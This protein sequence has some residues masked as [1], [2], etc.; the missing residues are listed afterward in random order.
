MVTNM[1]RKV[2]A[3]TVRHRRAAL[4]LGVVVAGGN[5]AAVGFAPSLGQRL[6]FPLFTVVLALLVLGVVSWRI[7]PACFVVQ[8][9]IPAFAAP[10]PAWRVYLALGVL[11]PFSAQVG[12][13][14]RSSSQGNLWLPEPFLDV[15]WFLLAVLLFSDAWRGHGVQL[16]PHGIRQGYTLGS[17]TVP[18][19]ALPVGHP[20]TPTK[21]PSTLRLAYAEPHLVRRRG[22]PLNRNA[23]RTDDIDARFLAAAIRHYACNPEHRATIGTPEEYECLL[24]ELPDRHDATRPDDSA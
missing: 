7:R 24:T 6:F 20:A 10:V 18:W 1:I 11:V 17:L 5:A 23:I 4:A 19:E 9:R 16:G 21:R 22:F 12:A 15:P 14:M 13:L 2:L 8:P 3:A